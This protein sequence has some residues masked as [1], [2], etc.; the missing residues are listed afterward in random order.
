MSSFEFILPSTS[1]ALAGSESALHLLEQKQRTE[2]S[3]ARNDP[4]L[5][6]DTS[7]ALLEATYKTIL[8]DRGVTFNTS[9]DMNM[10]YK[11]V[12]NIMTYNRD[13][14]AKGMLEKLIGVIAHWVPELRNKFGASSHGKDGYFLNP[15]ETPEAEMVV[16][17][18]DGMAG[19]LLIKNRMLSTPEN[20]QRIYYPDH[21]EFNEY[22]DTS[23]D[24][25][26][27]KI[28]GSKPIPYSKF[29]FD[30]EPEAYKEYLIQFLTQKKEEE[31]EQ[32]IIERIP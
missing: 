27:L 22:L 18:V 14:E 25:L 32:P 7:K 8:T 23:N 1:K 4:A 5:M 30:Y 15:I 6:L 24:P 19:F 31:E 16:H 26:D 13:D 20:S 11:Q 29:L 2:L 3:V 12:K 10:L 28:N 9:D 17:L 21:E